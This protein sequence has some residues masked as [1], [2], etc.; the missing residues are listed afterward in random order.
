MRLKRARPQA[1]K[2]KKEE[3][4]ERRR[5]GEMEERIQMRSE[6]WRACMWLAFPLR[7]LVRVC[8]RLQSSL[9]SV[10]LFCDLRGQPVSEV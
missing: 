5:G 1:N 2:K 4:R 9:Q 3:E 8:R 6:E 10:Q 7:L